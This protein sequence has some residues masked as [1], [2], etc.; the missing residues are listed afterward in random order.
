[1]LHESDAVDALA[2]SGHY[3]VIIYGHTH[4]VD[5]RA[6]KTLVINPGETGGWTTG[7][8]TVVVLDLND[9]NTELVDL[10]V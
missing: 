6:D 10:D 7:R 1:M 3:D 2:D 9:M 8:S 5:I 4:Q